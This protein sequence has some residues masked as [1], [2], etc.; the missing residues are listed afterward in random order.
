MPCT[1][2]AAKVQLMPT[3]TPSQQVPESQREALRAWMRQVLDEEFPSANQW[4]NAAR[5]S[6]SNITRFMANDDASMPT[7]TTISKLAAATSIPPPPVAQTP[8]ERTALQRV[9][10][11]PD[12]SSALLEEDDY[13]SIVALAIKPGMGGGAF[14]DLADETTRVLL[15]RRL[16]RD[17]LRAR[18]EDMRLLEVRGP[19][20][21]P[22]LE[23]GDHILVNI[24]ERN[25]SPAGIFCLWDGFGVVCKAVERVPRTNPPLLRL[26]SVNPI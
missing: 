22:M 9:G 19:S 8:H 17:H 16:I 24:A 12:L 25:P 7:W 15:P 13:V 1:A 20:M 11:I 10:S 26:I 3:P 2:D 14:E 6:P 21:S 4:A 23:E 5:T 18:P